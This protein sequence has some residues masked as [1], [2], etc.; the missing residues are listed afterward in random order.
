MLDAIVTIQAWWREL[1][2]RRIFRGRFMSRQE[3]RKRFQAIWSSC[4]NV[5]SSM[6]TPEEDCTWA[7]QKQM[8]H[9]VM[10]NAE[11]VGDDL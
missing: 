5:L 2:V 11:L 6:Q 10:R 8:D 9:D 3:R 1:K 7:T 4:I